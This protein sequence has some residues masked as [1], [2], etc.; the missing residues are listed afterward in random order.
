LDTLGQALRHG[1]GHLAVDAADVLALDTAGGVHQGI[2][3]LAVG[4]QQ[5]QAGGVEVQAADRDP[6]RA[7]QPRQRFEHGRPALGILAGG[8]LALGL[9][10]QQHRRWLAQGGGDEGLA[11]ELDAVAAAY[12]LADLGDFAI[13]PDQALGDALLEGAAGTEPGLG[14][15]LVQAFLGAG[16]GVAVGVLRLERQDFACGAHRVRSGSACSPASSWVSEAAASPPPSWPGALAPSLSSCSAGA[17]A[18][19]SSCVSLAGTAP[20]PASP[21]ASPVPSPIAALA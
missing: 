9:V 18:S 15:H 1:I 10:V 2:G 12:R 16:G 19:A 5:Q 11:V 8:D 21:V 7:L 4:G 13:D 20:S 14:Q 3:Q 17:C 6:A